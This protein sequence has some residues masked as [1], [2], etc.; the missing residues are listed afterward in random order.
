MWDERCRDTDC[1]RPAADDGRPAAVRLVLADVPSADLP[2]GAV[3]R[4]IVRSA[5]T[6]RVWRG[7][8]LVVSQR[9]YRGERTMTPFLIGADNPTGALVGKVEVGAVRR[10]TDT[11]EFDAAEARIS[12]FEISRLRGPTLAALK[13]LH[14]HGRTEEVR[15]LLQ[16][17]NVYRLDAQLALFPL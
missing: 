7:D 13:A 12:T 2:R 5:S 3:A 15:A 4:F 11:N 6:L 16:E 14:Q 10:A 1:L 8:D 17:T 9:L